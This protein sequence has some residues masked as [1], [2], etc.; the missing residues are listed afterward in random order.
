MVGAQREFAQSDF[1]HMAYVSATLIGILTPSWLMR[2][3]NANEYE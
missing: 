2:E 3:T 1:S